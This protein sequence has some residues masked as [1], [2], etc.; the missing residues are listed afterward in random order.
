MIS[1]CPLQEATADAEQRWAEEALAEVQAAEELAL[2]E[3][4]ALEARPETQGGLSEVRIFRDFSRFFEIFGCQKY[5][6]KLAKNKSK[7]PKLAVLRG[8]V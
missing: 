6:E 3:V 4:E 5:G 2:E 7:D 1:S 8:Y